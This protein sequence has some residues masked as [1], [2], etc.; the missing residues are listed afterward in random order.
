MCI[1]IIELGGNKGIFQIPMW[2]SENTEFNVVIKFLVVKS[3]PVY[4]AGK[5]KPIC[6]KVFTMS[7][8][9]KIFGILQTLLCGIVVISF[10]PLKR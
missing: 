10:V 8:E 4:A 9:K 3:S 6:V 2:F 7:F 1:L 5:H